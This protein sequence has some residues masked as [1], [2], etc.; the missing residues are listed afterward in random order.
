MVQMIE[1]DYN[2]KVYLI[3]ELSFEDESE[4]AFKYKDEIY[5]AM[6]VSLSILY[7]EPEYKKVPCFMA[8]DIVFELDRGY[9]E[10]HCDNC[11]QHYTEIEEYEKCSY[12]LTIKD[13]L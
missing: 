6:Y 7:Q 10:E 11:I 13:K 4:L 5:D 3:P 8:N 12:L 2:D 1:L 9:T